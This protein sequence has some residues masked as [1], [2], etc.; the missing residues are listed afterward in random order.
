MHERTRTTTV[1]LLSRKPREHGN[2]SVEMIVDSLVRNL[3]PD[4]RPEIHVS[5]FESNG[6]FRR[7]YNI[8]EAALRQ[9]DVNHVTGDVNFLSLLL[10]KDRTVLTILDCG[11]IEGRTDLRARILKLVWFQLPVQR[12]AVVTVISESVKESLLQHVRVAPSKVRVVPVAV[13]E[14][15]KASPRAFDAV[16]P[17]ILQIGTAPNKNLPRLIEALAGIPC[18]LE[19]VGKLSPEHLDLL[20]Q[21]AI[22]YREYARLT[23]EE[24]QER[25]E[26]CDLVAFASTFEGF[27]MPI[28]EANRVGR[29]VVAGNVTSMPAVAGDAACLV[30]PFDVSSIR[31]GILRVIGDRAYRD[32]LVRRG[33]ENARRFEPATVARMYEDIYR[34]IRD[35]AAASSA[36]RAGLVRRRPP[37]A[38]IL[39]S[40]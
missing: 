12:S 17:V 30:D 8:V 1:S 31:A 40:K 14:Q 38:P 6:L 27:G 22:E 37:E 23:N 36:P 15:F 25:Y 33:Y 35:H 24:M 20:R 19:I 29:P 28:V 11:S 2:F 5:K 7:L 26:Q 3:S 16:H 18:R 32:E 13:P 10:R 9:G 39:A 34:E 21:H 4:F